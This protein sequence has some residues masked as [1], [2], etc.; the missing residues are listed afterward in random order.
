MVQNP[1]EADD[2][3]KRIGDL[4]ISVPLH[5]IYL[6]ETDELVRLLSQDIAEWRHEPDRQV[7]VHAV[8]AAHSLAG[9]S[10]TVGFMPLQE[11][12]HALEMILQ[13]LARKP[14]RLVGNEYDTL[15]HGVERIRFMLQMFALG[16]MPEYEPAQVQQLERMQ[17]EIEARLRIATEQRISLRA[18][19]R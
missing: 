11:V 8:H 1:A 10:A 15:E 14:V 16:E 6:A 17:A 12:A 13:Y 3:V 2:S 4:E 9:T 7:N 5:N 19:R 18:G